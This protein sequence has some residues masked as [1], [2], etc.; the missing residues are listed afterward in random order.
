M[1]LPMAKGD[2][3]HLLV[4]DRTARGFIEKRMDAVKFVP[5]LPGTG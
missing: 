5:L 1:I 3:Q 2:E 4:I